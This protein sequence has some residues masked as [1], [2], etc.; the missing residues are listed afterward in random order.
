[1]NMAVNPM[2][3]SLNFEHVQGSP[4]RKLPFLT[5]R[6]LYWGVL[7]EAGILHYLVWGRG[8]WNLKSAILVTTF[9]LPVGLRSQVTLPL[10]VKSWI[11][12]VIVQAELM[13]PGSIR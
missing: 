5:T 13:V 9:V 8:W 4:S 12:P 7:P 6:E 3:S 11:F 2:L 10:C 1:M